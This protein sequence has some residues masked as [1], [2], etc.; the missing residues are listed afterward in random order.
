MRLSFYWFVL[1]LFMAINAC[2]PNQLYQRKDLDA[3]LL[4]YHQNFRWGRLKQAAQY[5][6][7]QLQADFVQSWLKHWDDMELHNVEVLS[8]IEKENG[9]VVEVAI[10]VQ[11]ID[12]TTMNLKEKILQETWV[13]TKDGW[14]LAGP[15]FPKDLLNQ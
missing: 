11:W 4:K 1:T 13:R 9:D 14:L 5:V 15:V 10:K 3:A 8:L 2:A 12:Q 7:P 6:Q